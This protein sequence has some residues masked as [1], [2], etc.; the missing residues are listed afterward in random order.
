MQDNQIPNSPDGFVCGFVA[1]A[2]RPNVGKSSLLNYFVGRKISIISRKPQTTRNRLLGIHTTDLAQVIFVDTPGIH[3]NQK[4]EINRV[5]NRTAVSSLEG[6]DVILMMI[7]ARGWRDEDT[8]VYQKVKNCGIP[9]VLAINKIDRLKEKDRLLPL[10]TEVSE[11]RNFKEMVPVSAKS[12]ENMPA[13]L[14]ALVA[15]MPEGPQG[16]PSEQFTDRSQRFLAS[17]L[18]REKMFRFLGQELPYSSTVEITR[19]ETDDT[20]MIHIDATIWVE[21]PGQKAIVIGKSGATMKKI[22][23]EARLEMERLFNCRIY[24]GLWAKVRKGWTDN[25]KALKSLGFDDF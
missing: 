25:A 3:A 14:S 6:V 21:K 10:M 7:D 5:I 1:I 12:G 18:V 17:E 22:G 11:H 20:G 15:L 23:M 19:F 16:F 4:S 24:L 13:L 2:G 8:L 9:V